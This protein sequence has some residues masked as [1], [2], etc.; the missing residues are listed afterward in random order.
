[1]F[2]CGKRAQ[3][4]LR[5]GEGRILNPLNEQL[6]AFQRFASTFDPEILSG[7][8]SEDGREFI[9]VDRKQR[10]FSLDVGGGQLK[11]VSASKKVNSRRG[12]VSAALH[13]EGYQYAL[14]GS[15]ASIVFGSVLEGDKV[16]FPAGFSRSPVALQFSP[17][18]K[19]VALSNGT[20]I[21]LFSLETGRFNLLDVSASYLSFS[22]DG[23]TALICQL[24]GHQSVWDISTGAVL[25]K[26]I[27]IGD[28]EIKA[29]AIDC[30]GN[31]AFFALG[32]GEVRQWDISSGA[33]TTLFRSHA[34]AEIHFLVVAPD[35]SRLVSV[36]QA[37][38]IIVWSMAHGAI[39]GPV[40]HTAPNETVLD[41]NFGRG[42]LR[43]AYESTGDSRS[44]E[45]WDI[46]WQ[47]KS[48]GGAVVD[49]SLT[50]VGAWLADGSCLL[51]AGPDLPTVRG[52]PGRDELLGASIRS[53]GLSDSARATLE[54]SLTQGSLDRL[55]PVLRRSS[56]NIEKMIASTYQ[57]SR[58]IA[59]YEKIANIPFAGVLS[60]AWDWR[61]GDAFSLR[62]PMMIRLRSGGLVDKARENTFA[63]AWL[64][65][66]P[67]KEIVAIG[68]RELQRRVAT[69]ETF[70]RFISAVAG[71]APLLFLGVRA[72]EVADFLEYFLG[73]D[74][75]LLPVDD[76][77]RRI[78]AICPH[79]DLW[80]LD[81]ERLSE[82]Y[83]VEPFGYTSGN[84]LLA[85]CNTLHTSVVEA[86]EVNRRKAFRSVNQDR[87]R[88]SR[89]RLINIGP[90][91]QL[92][93]ELGSGWN[94]LLGDNGC[95]KSTVLRAIGL[96][97]CGD[98]PSAV[99]AGAALLRA[100]ADRGS[101][102]LVIGKRQY[103]TELLRTGAA[104]RV[105]TGALSALQQVP[106]IVVGF[107]ALRGMGVTTPTG[108]SAPSSSMP[109]EDDV[110]PL[111]LGVVDQRLDDIKQW[112]INQELRNE[113]AVADSRHGRLLDRFFAVMRDLSPAGQVSFDSIDRET[114]AVN[115]K[116]EYG[117][118]PI[119]QLSQGVS[120]TIA[121]V[122]TL[123]QRMYDVYP[124]SEDPAG[125]AALLLVDELDA[126]LHPAWQ[127][128]LPSLVRR[129]FPRVQVVATSHSPLIAS[130]LKL[131]EL[132]VASR[133][134]KP[135][136]GDDGAEN[137]VADVI[138]SNVDPKGLR[139]DQI[140]TTPLFGLETS[141]STI[142]EDDKARYLEL[143]ARDHLDPQEE[144][145]ARQLGL[146]MADAYLGGETVQD[147][148]KQRERIAQVR[149]RTL[150]AIR[151]ASTDDIEEFRRLAGGELPSS[152]SQVAPTR[153]TE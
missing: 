128:E 152:E 94:M 44:I 90:F 43:L 10:F 55:A 77:Q 139:A 97:I 138:R 102:E 133:V 65:G 116:T 54:E 110:L 87:P 57:D 86:E 1:M 28:V 53:L 127:R 12:I 142:F 125:E 119:E 25:A 15:D 100:G 131:G 70:G 129:H 143:L 58:N 84:D 108:L 5:L 98:H 61:L 8:F 62:D 34:K 64:A 112:I 113:H 13:A 69:D 60:L 20:E 121:W 67:L 137:V 147:R 109:T 51:I 83:N 120:S 16:S 122:G 144:V 27:S 89:L 30:N 52:L 48:S 107:P 124:E 80:D 106:W 141:R 39:S 36:D 42:V 46:A 99:S 33:V 76:V 118:I 32:T 117:V 146:E 85:I 104:V 72:A 31:F 140:L 11:S 96:G 153:D 150:D 93:L 19:I 37:G 47:S 22:A 82:D 59:E 14:S 135:A 92:T 35:A 9:L 148:H 105:R 23:N 7:S 50:D 6:K 68:P 40:F 38:M 88:L 115:V 78:V 18:G 132:F 17:S 45:V 29:C 26:R 63:F 2:K 136:F 3:N 114:W 49:A 130:G 103:R 149:S 56:I 21:A 151:S 126:H 41:A 81:R 95:G 66:D 79:D 75:V 91:E 123:L 111:V 134:R 71:S 74:A 101:I 73:M 24:D 4:A 145:E